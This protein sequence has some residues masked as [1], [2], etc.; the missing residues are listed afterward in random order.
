MTE[1]LA[2]AFEKAS[3]LPPEVQDEVGAWLLAELESEKRWTALFSSSRDALSR[4]AAEAVDEHSR[5]RTKPLDP[6][7]L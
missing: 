5:G 1:I 7:S 4:L 3:A 6:E 2:K